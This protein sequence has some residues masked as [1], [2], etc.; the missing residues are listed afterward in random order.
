M[1]LSLLDSDLLRLDPKQP[2]P[3]YL[4]GICLYYQGQHEQAIA[5]ATAALKNDPDF[6]KA[7]Y[8]V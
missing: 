3:L 5:H 7:R 6:S 8:V 2:E 4:R 1:M